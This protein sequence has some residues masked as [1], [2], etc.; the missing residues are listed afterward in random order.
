MKDPHQIKVITDSLNKE[1]EKYM[2]E[3]MRINSL[4]TNKQSMA[5][6]MQLY[7]NDY[8]NNKNLTVSKSIPGLHNNITQFVKKMNSV[9]N[10]AEFEVETI[11][12]I[13][14]S[15]LEIIEKINQKIDLMNIFDKKVK[16][17]QIKKNEKQ[18]QNV[19]DDLAATLAGVD[20]E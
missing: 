4:L 7:L 8:L 12:Q 11:L 9:I 17:D 2:H 19:I 15:V 18:E 16:V 1:K 14:T 13:R 3:L 6:K 20:N 10:Q 5:E